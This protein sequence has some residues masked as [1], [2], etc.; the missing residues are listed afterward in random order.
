[1]TR[2]LE[3]PLAP[4]SLCELR[5]ARE[6]AIHG[7]GLGDPVELVPALRALQPSLS[8]PVRQRLSLGAAG[9]SLYTGD[10]GS[11]VHLEQ[12]RAQGEGSLVLDA[13]GGD[14]L[15]VEVARRQVTS[16]RWIGVAVRPLATT[17][18][19]AA[20]LRGRT[21]DQERRGG[22]S[23]F[24]WAATQVALA[25][26]DEAGEVESIT[27]GARPRRWGANDLVAAAVAWEHLGAGRRWPPVSPQPASGALPVQAARL[28]ALVRAFGLERWSGVEL[29]ATERYLFQVG[30]AARSSPLDRLHDGAFLLQ[31]PAEEQARARRLILELD[32]AADFNRV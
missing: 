20:V 4:T 22:R 31:R 26:N 10:Y 13:D 11:D 3:L 18:E 9:R 7:I 2:R 25:W 14:A 29:E 23:T 12:V 30:A 17:R 21:E 5:N 28:A 27:L 19:A 32:P 1:M 16:L 6:Y 24:T 8:D 15:V